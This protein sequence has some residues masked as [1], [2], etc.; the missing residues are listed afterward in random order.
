MNLEQRWHDAKAREDEAKRERLEIEKII[1]QAY[2]EKWREENKNT[3]HLDTLTVTTGVS[4]KWDT[5][6]LSQVE[7]KL[8]LFPFTKKVEYKCNSEL[9]KVVEVS[10]PEEYNILMQ[11]VE[12]KPKKPYF[13]ARN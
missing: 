7:D 5:S 8:S 1:Y 4:Q 11:H 10:H 9:L 12:M 13:K 3:H 2:E 6:A